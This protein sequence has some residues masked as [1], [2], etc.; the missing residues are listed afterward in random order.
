VAHGSERRFAPLAA[1][2]AGQAAQPG[3]EAADLIRA[4]RRDLESPGQ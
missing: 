3:I 2:L 4:V 1:Y